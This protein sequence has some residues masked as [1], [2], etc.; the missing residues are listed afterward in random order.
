MITF[1]LKFVFPSRMQLSLDFKFDGNVVVLRGHGKR[2]NEDQ[3]F[4][5]DVVL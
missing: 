3:G 5:V 2:C 4:Q 1:H